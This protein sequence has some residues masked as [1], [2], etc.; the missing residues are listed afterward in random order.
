MSEA[1]TGA[2]A[3]LRNKLSLRADG[4]SSRPIAREDEGTARELAALGSVHLEERRDEETGE[5]ALY[6]WRLT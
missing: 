3:T 2:Q 5:P 4:L 1:L 6:A